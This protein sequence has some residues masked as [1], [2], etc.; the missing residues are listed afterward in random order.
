L[1][2]EAARFAYRAQRL[3]R[4]VFRLQQK[5][6]S[7]FF[8]G[9]LDLIAGYG[10]RPVR[11]LIAYLVMILFFMGL[12]LLNAHFVAPHLKW[13]EA[14]VLSVSSFHGRGFFSQDISLG[15]TYARLAAAEAVVGLLIEIS[16][17][18]T[19]TQRYFGK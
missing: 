11:S 4:S 6:G 3:Q 13:D 1:H 12:Y 2:E 17:I 16:L 19:F 7:Y 18:A 15:D 8:S 10:Y 9:F 5:F 14:L